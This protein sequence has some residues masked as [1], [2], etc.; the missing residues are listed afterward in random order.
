MSSE[1]YW[2]EVVGEKWVRYD[3]WYRLVKKK[4]I[5]LVKIIWL[6]G[7]YRKK[8]KLSRNLRLGVGLDEKGLYRGNKCDEGFR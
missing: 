2:I 8:G 6:L 5:N 3:P 1:D 7:H 4:T